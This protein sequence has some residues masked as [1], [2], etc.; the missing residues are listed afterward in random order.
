MVRRAVSADDRAAAYRI[1]HAVFV[2]EQGVPV[3]LERDERDA[4]AGHFIACLGDEVVGAVRVVIEPPGF[5]GTDAAHGAITH[6]GR[7][8]VLPE[9]RGQGIGALLVAAVESHAE[10]IGLS[11]VY[12]GAQAHALGFYEALGYRAY[13][14][15]FDDAGLPHR[16]MVR[17]IGA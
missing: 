12:L 2:D 5:E 9:Q 11:A 4:D 1:R 8:A 6:L 3:Q 15:E 7:L 14:E 17:V 16:H 13:G 10:S